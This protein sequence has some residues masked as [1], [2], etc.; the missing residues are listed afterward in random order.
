M[1]RC[2]EERNASTAVENLLDVCFWPLLR[3]SESLR[4]DQQLQSGYSLSWTAYILA[5]KAS[6]AVA[7]E[8]DRA[9]VLF[10]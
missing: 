6:Q 1:V 10:L 3:C 9:V 4:V 8:Y 5:H 2:A 7:N